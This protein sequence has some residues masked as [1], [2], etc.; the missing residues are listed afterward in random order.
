[1]IH[2]MLLG[3]EGIVTTLGWVLRVF[4][5]VGHGLDWYNA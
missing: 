2:E 5:D 1:M 3:S 4:R